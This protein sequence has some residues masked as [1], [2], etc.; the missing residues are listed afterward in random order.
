MLADQ[1]EGRLVTPGVVFCCL[2][3]FGGLLGPERLPTSAPSAQPLLRK[4]LAT[5]AHT[6][7]VH[8]AQRSKVHI[9][10]LGW[11]LATSSFASTNKWN[12]QEFLPKHFA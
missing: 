3:W 12:Q 10:I 6:H 9:F 4:G 11:A 5:Y 8:G 2:N 1:E 7:A